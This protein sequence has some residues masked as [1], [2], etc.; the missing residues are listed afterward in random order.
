M[1]ERTTPRNDGAQRPRE[2]KDSILRRAVLAGAKGGVAGLL[3]GGGVSLLA[4]RH[5]PFYQR[6]SASSKAAVVSMSTL[7]GFGLQAERQLLVRYL[8]LCCFYCCLS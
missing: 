6:L 7:F 3:A 2:V 8:Y 5:W 4:R 1:S